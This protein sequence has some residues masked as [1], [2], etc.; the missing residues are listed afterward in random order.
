MIPE[1]DIRGVGRR[2]EMVRLG[3]DSYE[4]HEFLQDYLDE[5][6]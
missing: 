4:H 2:A 3:N 5:S 6:K 1:R